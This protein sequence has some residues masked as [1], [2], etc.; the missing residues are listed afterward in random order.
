MARVRA[1]V[2]GAP[3]MRNITARFKT[4]GRV[5]LNQ[6]LRRNIGRAGQPV[7]AEIRAAAMAVRITSSRDGQGRP[8]GSTHLRARVAAATLLSQTKNGIRFKVSANRVDPNG[9]G[10]TLPRYLDASI[11][12]RFVRW[13]HPVFF[14]G[15]IGEAPPRR[16]T[17]QSGSPFFFVTIKRHKRDFEKAVVSAVDE[18]A[19]EMFG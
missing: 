12:R 8:K 7:V 4:A 9:Y 17:Q 6:K 5:D 18:A 13:R 14:P 15:P 2:R 1:T 10:V 16:V 19:K 11:N 3:E